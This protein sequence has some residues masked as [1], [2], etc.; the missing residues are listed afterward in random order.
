MWKQRFSIVELI[1]VISV[2]AILAAIIIPT[3]HRAREIANKVLCASHLRQ[4]SAG[5]TFYAKDSDGEYPPFAWIMDPNEKNVKDDKIFGGDP[6]QGHGIGLMSKLKGGSWLDPSMAPVMICPSD[7]NPEL[8]VYSSQINADFTLGDFNNTTVYNQTKKM[9][10]G[11][12]KVESSY[13]YNLN[14][15]LYEVKVLGIQDPSTMLVNFDADSLFG[16]GMKKNGASKADLTDFDTF[17]KDVFEA[18]HLGEA[19]LL[20]ADGHV[21]SGVAADINEDNL[22]A[23]DWRTTGNGYFD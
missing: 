13:G 14:L 1:V 9:G 17:F 21:K 16:D 12:V 10:P 7:K 3:M 5:Y 6:P 4:L 15:G 8:R 2:I 11:L 20:F 18:R 19:N 23:D 22:Y